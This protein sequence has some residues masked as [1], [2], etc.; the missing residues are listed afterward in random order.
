MNIKSYLFNE[1]FT[2]DD[3]DQAVAL[4]Y[5]TKSSEYLRFDLNNGGSFYF[6]NN[7]I[8]SF[9]DY[10]ENAVFPGISNGIDSKGVRIIGPGN[11]EEFT[12]ENPDI[13]DYVRNL[14]MRVRRN[15]PEELRRLPYFVDRINEI[16][17]TPNG[18]IL[19]L[20]LA[21][22]I[23]GRNGNNIF[24]KLASGIDREVSP[25]GL[26]QLVTREHIVGQDV[27][28]DKVV[29]LRLICFGILIN[30]KLWDLDRL[31]PETRSFLETCNLVIDILRDLLVEN[32][33]AQTW[34]LLNHTTC[35]GTKRDILCRY[36]EDTELRCDDSI[37][38]SEETYATARRYILDILGV[39]PNIVDNLE[40][41]NLI[42]MQD[43]KYMIGGKNNYYDKYI[44]YKNKYLEIKKKNKY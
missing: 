5:N 3:V 36:L 24:T 11:L 27:S 34:E 40:E 35:T 37:D 29:N 13:A 42:F 16:A 26:E 19:K 17:R 31:T 9:Q 6:D 30:N 38:F 39:I 4:N 22:M 14:Y 41:N 43:G 15:S 23:R 10:P 44:K 28:V 32:S 12:R 33:Y 18:K 20:I 2:L 7:T 1:F 21:I 8:V 25:T